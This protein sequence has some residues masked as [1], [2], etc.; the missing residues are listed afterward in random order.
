MYSNAL[1]THEHNVSP[2]PLFS[3]RSETS[4]LDEKPVFSFLRPVEK[5]S[6]V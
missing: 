3:A 5:F 1:S 2:G 4:G 6:K